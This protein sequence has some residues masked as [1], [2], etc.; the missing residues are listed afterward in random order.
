MANASFFVND[1]E[2]KNEGEFTILKAQR[3]CQHGTVFDEV[4][5]I[6]SAGC[7]SLLKNMEQN[8]HN[9]TSQNYAENQNSLK[10]MFTRFSEDKNN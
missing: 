2:V 7:M 3:K 10:D 9:L 6:M 8:Q 1:V 5:L 4:F